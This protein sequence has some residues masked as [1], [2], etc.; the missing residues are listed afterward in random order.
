MR[1]YRNTRREAV[2]QFEKAIELDP[3]NLAAHLHYAQMLEQLN[4]PWRARPHAVCVLE[5]DMNHREARA[6]LNF[7]DTTA[8]RHASRASLLDRLT[9][10]HSR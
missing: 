4:M 9:G 6:R 8:P 5:L 2:E 1:R 3:R 10:R 7:L